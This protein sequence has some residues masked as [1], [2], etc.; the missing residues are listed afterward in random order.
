LHRDAALGEA[1]TDAVEV[2]CHERAAPA[3]LLPARA[4]HEMLDQQLAPALKQIGLSARS[5]GG[6]ED[7]VLLSASTLKTAVVMAWTQ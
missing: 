1:G 5:G 7:R 2:H 4:E 3:A 6:V